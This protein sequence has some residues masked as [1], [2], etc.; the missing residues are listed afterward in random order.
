MRGVASGVD[1]F[2]MEARYSDIGCRKRH[3]MWHCFMDPSCIGQ[4]HQSVANRRP[5]RQ[6]LHSSGWWTGLS[7]APGCSSGQ[8]VGPRPRHPARGPL[9]RP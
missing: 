7:A 2:V 1:T 4:T 5:C 6:C 9:V 8:W 3:Q